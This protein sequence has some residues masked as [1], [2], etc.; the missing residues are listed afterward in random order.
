MRP[1][2]RVMATRLLV[3]VVALG[4]IGSA[5]SGDEGAVD[6]STTTSSPAAVTTIPPVADT[7][8]A[9]AP[10]PTA[11]ST[12]SAVAALPEYEIAFREAGEDGDTVVVLL[13]P[14]TFTTL[15]EIDVQDIVV[16]V[17]ERFSPVLVA[18]VV[19]TEDA[20]GYVLLE[21]LT[22]EQQDHLDLHYWARL[23]EGL[24]IVFQGQLA[25]AGFAILGS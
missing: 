9:P 3:A 18:H 10:D 23:E 19:D 7:T 14:S 25:D 6:T 8:T 20:A 16:D 11:P 24:R 2:V 17:Y 12:T 1:S 15:S 4:M 13:D 21:T 5:C 22:E